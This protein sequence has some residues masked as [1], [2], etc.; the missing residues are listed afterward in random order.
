MEFLFW[1]LIDPTS[2]LA[3]PLHHHWRWPIVFLSILNAICA[4]FLIYTIADRIKKMKP[5]E[6]TQKQRWSFIGAATM[7]FGV[8][9]MHFTAMQAC[10]MGIPFS[11]DVFLTF[12]SIAPAMIGSYFA[13][14]GMIHTKTFKSIQ[15]NAL[16]MAL[17][18]G[19]MHYTGME[20]IQANTLMGYDP[21]YFIL[22]II[23]AHIFAMISLQIK[24][25]QSKWIKSKRIY[26][27]IISALFMGIA[28]SAMHYTAMFSSIF[29]PSNEVEQFSSFNITMNP[30][31]LG[32]VLFVSTIILML[33]VVVTSHLEQLFTEKTEI[34]NTIISKTPAGIFTTDRKGVI[35]QFNSA[36]EKIFSLTESEA[37]GMNIK[38]L[39]ETD[40]FEKFQEK[41]EHKIHT[42]NLNTE[43]Q[44]LDAFSQKNHSKFPVELS[45]TVSIVEDKPMIINMVKD[46]TL[47]KEMEE[48]KAKLI[49]NSKLASLGEMAG[50]I[51]HEINNPLGVIS[52][53]SEQLI[54]LGEQGKLTPEMRDKFLHQ[55]HECV[56]R[57]SSIVK[58]LR[59]LS[60]DSTSDPMLEAS[61]SEI[62]NSIKDLSLERLKHKGVM[63]DTSEVHGDL[64]IKCREVQISQVLINL[65]NNAY[66]AIKDEKEKWIKI[67]TEND[68]KEIRISVL[69]SGNGIPKEI[70][71]KITQPFFTTKPIGQGTGLGLSVSHSIIKNHDGDLFVDSKEKNT[72][73]TIKLPKT[74]EVNNG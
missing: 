32:V 22:S 9:A 30:D 24:H 15:F 8:W 31:I 18:I 36:S 37:I 7:G 40:S 57:I 21:F 53:R 48:T 2:I 12:I 4:A 19:T 60:R 20:A 47:Q 61:L 6:K 14:Q 55:I 65:I 34:L 11:Y 42:M 5:E 64:K 73:F 67:K 39:F 25:L 44:E 49:S 68:P 29:I 41:I 43:T 74:T 72:C 10:D 33:G 56:R 63:L 28:V 58:G 71:D 26:K 38:K 46:L 16:C 17:G 3:Q 52:M 70:L 35:Q 45:S 59:S 13:L 54:K 69:D 51:A 66:D 50:G 62:I 23:A 1:R 27:N